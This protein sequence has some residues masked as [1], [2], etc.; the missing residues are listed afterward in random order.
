[1][2]KRLKLRRKAGLIAGLAAVAL[3]AGGFALH[4][5]DV[6]ADADRGDRSRESVAGQSP[7]EPGHLSTLPV[8]E[9][10]IAVAYSDVTHITSQEFAALHSERAEDLV[11]LDVR[12]AD[13]Y[14]V[15]RI[16]GAI[17]VDP[18]AGAGDVLSAAGDIGDR[19]VILYCSVGAR[20]SAMARRIGGQLLAG[21]ARSVANLRGGIFRWHNERRE[22]VDADGPT[23]WVHRF[24]RYWGQ[25]LTRQNRAV[26]QRRDSAGSVGR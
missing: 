10:A 6:V 13:E 17:R 20:S 12:E 24:D 3:G 11:V 22:L 26:A 25:L 19:R 2:S 9:T 21:G 7:G 5:V 1:M 18:S 14:Q 4:H 15:S 16:D 23:P 8:I